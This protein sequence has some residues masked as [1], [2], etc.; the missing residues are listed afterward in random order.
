MVESISGNP[1]GDKELD[2]HTDEGGE[3][4]KDPTSVPSRLALHGIPC[5]YTVLLLVFLADNYFL[6]RRDSLVT[7]CAKVLLVEGVD[8]VDDLIA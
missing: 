8:N 4:K 6:D 5:L 2:S 1:E 7:E 3:H